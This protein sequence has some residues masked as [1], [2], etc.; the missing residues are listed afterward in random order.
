MNEKRRKTDDAATSRGKA[1][2]DASRSAA[3]VIAAAVSSR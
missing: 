1:D 3:A 2:A